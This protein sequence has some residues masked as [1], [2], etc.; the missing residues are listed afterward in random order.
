MA[1]EIGRAATDGILTTIGTTN[2]HS[3]PVAI[4]TVLRIQTTLP[5]AG[6]G[7]FSLWRVTIVHNARVGQCTVLVHFT[8]TLPLREST[9]SFIQKAD[10]ASADLF[11]VTATSPQA[12]LQL[13]RLVTT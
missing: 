5:N 6:D 11:V 10:V 9:G 7:T 13:D 2:V 4:I 12:T 1:I 3:A 8:A